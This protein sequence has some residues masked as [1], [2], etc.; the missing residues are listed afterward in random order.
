MSLLRNAVIVV[1]AFLIVIPVPSIA[2]TL[3]VNWNAN[4]ETDL[5][6][7]L[8]YYGTQSGNYSAC[9]DV[10]KVT[11]YQITSVP[12]G[13]TV[14]IAMAAYDT[15]QRDSAL[16]AEQHITVPA[17]KASVTLLSPASGIIVSTAPTLKWSGTGITKYTVKRYTGSTWTTLYTGTGT[18]C[19]TS[20]FW[21]T[22]KSGATIY[23]YV[24]G[25]TSSGSTVKTSTRYFKKK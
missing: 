9:Y 24:I 19:S 4:T 8:I 1:L 14:Y 11:S 13:I 10:G 20:S 5:A 17:Q 18:S 15:S 21:S 7:Y 22:I 16:S 3:Q 6:G 12:N 23:W 25:T 2:A